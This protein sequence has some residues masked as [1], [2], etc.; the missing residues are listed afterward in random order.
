MR[1]KIFGSMA[2]GQCTRQTKLK[3]FNLLHLAVSNGTPSADISA[4]DGAFGTI[5]PV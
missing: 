2:H 3:L 5:L 1:F 4:R